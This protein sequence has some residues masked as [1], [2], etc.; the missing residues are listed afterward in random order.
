MKVSGLGSVRGTA[1]R[2]GSRK[3]GAAAGSFDVH[4]AGPSQATVR[5]GAVSGPAAVGALLSIQETGDQAG[6][7]ARGLAH[8]SDLLREL[9]QIRLGLLLGSIQKARLER[10]PRM[11]RER[12]NAFS[13][14]RLNEIIS[15]I[16]VRAAVELAKFERA[17]LAAL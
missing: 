16:E 2:R 14:P 8:G 10:H 13:D 4:G 15:E 7:R 12:R 5:S 3:V 11:L 9:E 6:E 17:G 1:S